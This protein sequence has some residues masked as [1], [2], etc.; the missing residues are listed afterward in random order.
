[1]VYIYVAD[2][3]VDGPLRASVVGERLPGIA[4]VSEGGELAEVSGVG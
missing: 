2:L 3:D 4:E 1:V